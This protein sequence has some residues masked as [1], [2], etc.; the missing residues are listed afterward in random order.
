MINNKIYL[1]FVSLAVAFPFLSVNAAEPSGHHNVR[2]T[3]A[4]S[5]YAIRNTVGK[6]GSK[7]KKE[8]FS[9]SANGCELLI[10]WRLEWH[11]RSKGSSTANHGADFRIPFRLIK[12]NSIVASDRIKLS[13]DKDKGEC[14][15]KR[16][17]KEC[18]GRR[19]RQVRTI[20]DYY[21]RVDSSQKKK[22]S[23]RL[24]KMISICKTAKN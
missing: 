15:T 17:H 2:V 4:L 21:L 11:D 22:I 23:H 7:T 12:L 14:I 3:S 1:I 16:M 5:K 9:Y 6:I 20:S 10:N 8:R 19:C 18:R 13:C 24:G